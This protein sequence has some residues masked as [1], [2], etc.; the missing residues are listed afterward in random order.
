MLKERRTTGLSAASVERRCAYH[1][2]SEGKKTRLTK[3]HKGKTCKGTYTYMFK[4]HRTRKDLNRSSDQPSIHPPEQG[5]FESN[6]F[7]SSTP[8]TSFQETH[9]RKMLSSYKE[10]LHALCHCLT[11]A[12]AESSQ[13]SGL[14]LQIP[15]RVIQQAKFT[16]SAIKLPKLW[17][18]L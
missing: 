10:V 2:P 7:I 3:A 17:S 14:V 15:R 9:L 12:G 1:Q 16:Q 5:S 13:L 11:K 6:V 18:G 4:S 8:H